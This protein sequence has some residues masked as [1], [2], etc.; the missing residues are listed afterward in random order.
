MGREPIGCA[1]SNPF[2]HTREY[3]VEFMD[4]TTEKYATNVIA[5][6]MYAQVDDEGS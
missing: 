5:D 1:H 6:N 4:G 3:D 2:I